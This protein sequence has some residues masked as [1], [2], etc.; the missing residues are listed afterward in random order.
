[1]RTRIWHSDWKP[2]WLIRCVSAA[3]LSFMDKQ[4]NLW[5]YP[6]PYRD[7]KQ[8]A[9]GDGKELCD[10]LVVCGKFVIIFSEKSVS[11][12]SGNLDV[13]WARW[14]KR[15]IR[16]AA[17]QA[18]GAERWIME[19]PNRIFLDRECTNVFPID[20]PPPE[21][22]VIHRVVVASGA[23]EACREHVEAG[24]GSL[25]IRPEIKGDEHWLGKREQ[26]Y[27][28]AVGDVDPSG[29]FVHVLNETSLELIMN[30]LD[31]ITDF[32]AYL[33]KKAFFVRSGRLLQA[34]GEENLLA[35]YAVR[36]NDDGDYD[37]V[38]PAEVSAD[39]LASLTI[40]ESHYSS[41]TQTP[42]Y[43]AKKQADKVSYLWDAL[44]ETFTTPMLEGT[45]VSIGEFDLELRQR[46][47]GVRYMALKRRFVRRS[48]G[49]AIEDALRIGRTNEIF[50]RL[51]LVPEGNKSNES[52]FFFMT[53]KFIQSPRPFKDYDEYRKA[54]IAMLHVYARGVLERY[55]YLERVIGVTCE[56][57][58]QGHGGSEDLIYAGQAQWTEEQRR[59]IREDCER[60][61][62]FR[63][64]LK[65]KLWKGEEYPDVAVVTIEPVRA[66][67][68]L[69]GLN[70]RHRRAM[71]ARHRKARK[72]R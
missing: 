26:L 45:T 5:S 68:Q 35:Y 2:R 18:R 7:Q 28:F 31:T 17:R 22:R 29:S 27:P 24:Y 10:L 8:G 61:E 42:Q 72:R 25:I 54:R 59:A 71:A 11:W 6:T 44:I 16:D 38:L 60:L 21:D 50:F 40:D 43:L 67:G 30:E 62:V 57:P 56:P 37:F 55:S 64:N 36:I 48:H 20:F 14:A 39:A 65:F 3:L 51:M 41:L 49:E 58:G 52:A 32:A 69:A 47:L 53:A 33:E 9:A 4:V 34:S 66:Q 13:A 63:P 19:F 23:A 1:M 46:E 70:R 15:A 12:P